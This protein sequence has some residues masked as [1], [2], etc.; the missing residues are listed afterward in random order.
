[1]NVTRIIFLTCFAGLLIFLSFNQHRHNKK[2]YFNYQSEIWADNAG[3]HVYLPATFI[4]GFDARKFPDSID[5]NT[6]NGFQ[7][8]L[9]TGI[10][11]TKY[12]YG[13][14]FLQAPFF[15]GAHVYSLLS[16]MEADGYGPAYHSAVNIAGIFYLIIGLLLLYKFLRFN[17][18]QTISFLS[19]AIIL[20]GTN[21]FYYGVYDTGK[22]HVYSFFLFSAFL[23]LIRQSKYLQRNRISDVILFGLIS[24]LII[25]VRP[26]GAMFLTVFFFLDWINKEEFYRRL[27]AIFNGKHF[28]ILAACLV[29]ISLPQL[30]YYK[31]VAG[32]FFFYSYS[33]EGFNFLDP[34]LY[35]TWFSPISGLFPYN[36]IY[37]VLIGGFILMIRQKVINGW[38]I[39]T[40]FL[41]ISFVFASWWDWSF[42]CSFG[43]RSFAEYTGLFSLSIAFIISGFRDFRTVSKVL[44]SVLLLACVFV[45]LKLFSAFDMCYFGDG[46]WDWEWFTDLILK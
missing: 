24:T 36:P 38:V 42:G 1:M 12:T 2:G 13:T 9:E 31:Y 34:N 26:T 29:V 27:H 15:L 35:Y 20:L 30:F 43:A 11:N 4:Y 8:N 28:L 45:N 19:V 16:G 22:S 18:N 3:Y 39:G 25:V 37:V 44:V 6:G 17:Y 23:Y 41:L 46:L 7:L 33:G 10:V 14:A 21:L 40:L 5:V 32:R